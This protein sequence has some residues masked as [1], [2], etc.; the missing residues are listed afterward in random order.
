MTFD[1]LL[2]HCGHAG[3]NLSVDWHVVDPDFLDRRDQCPCFAGMTLEK[4]FFLERADV[5]H[6]RSLARE[7]KM[8]LD[9]ARAR[10]ESALALF[11]LDKI[12][13]FSLPL[14]QHELSIAA[15]DCGASSNEHCARVAPRA[16][17][18]LFVI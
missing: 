6:D 5:L 4:S 9:L 16:S 17:Y 14:R 11:A 1:V 12:E 3:R 13:N 15:M 8:T 10:S 18:W 7:M 2:G